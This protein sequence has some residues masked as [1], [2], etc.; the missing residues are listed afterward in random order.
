MTQRATSLFDPFFA[1][2]TTRLD[3][4]IDPKKVAEN[5]GLM[6][7]AHHAGSALIKPIDKG[8]T[9]GLAVEAMRQQTDIQL[10][11][12]RR[13]IE[14]LAEQAMAIQ[15]RV[16]ISE[17]IYGAE[18]NFKPV[19]GHTYHLYDKADGKAVLSMIGPR[20]WGKRGIPYA[21]HA[22]TVRLMADH[23]WEVLDDL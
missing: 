10:A 17:R 7:Y 4:P 20:E 19:I 23:T 9:K 13:Q 2:K 15:R 16:E 5:P 3:N 12:I 14:L 21:A 8:R 22:A 1:E 11:Q 6:T 18:M